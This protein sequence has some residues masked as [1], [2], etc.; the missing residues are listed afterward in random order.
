MRN[1]GARVYV[2]HG[3]ERSGAVDTLVTRLVSRA[4]QLS[5]DEA[6]DLYRAHATRILVSGSDAERRALARARRTARAHG[7][8]H[9]YENARRAAVRAWREA[10]PGTGGPWLLVGQAIA[11]AAGAL[12]VQDSLDDEARQ[13]LLGPW[14]QSIGSLVP[15]GPGQTEPSGTTSARIG[16]ASGAEGRRPDR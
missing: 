15:V 6:A 5:L 14:R 13:L 7:R 12:V 9:E 11:N 1:A 10:L 2:S 16:A 3:M 4:G 8:E